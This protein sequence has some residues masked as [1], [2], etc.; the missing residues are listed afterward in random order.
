M[1]TF[2]TSK[3]DD[4]KG[5]TKTPLIPPA[6]P[7]IPVDKREDFI[8]IIM[9]GFTLAA[10]AGFVNAVAMLSSFAITVSHLT[11][12][13]TRLGFSLCHFDFSTAIYQFSIVLFYCFGCVLVGSFISNQRFYYSRK[14]GIFLIFE[15]AIIAIAA[16]LFLQENKLGIYFAAFGMGV[17]NS[18]FS[19][20]SGAVVRTT[21]VTG[22]VTDIGLLFG[23]WIRFKE[24]PKELWRLKVFVPLYVGYVFGA[25]LAGWFFS[26]LGVKAMYIPCIFLCATGVIWTLWRMK[27][28]LTKAEKHAI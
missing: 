25:L 6:A 4:I 16:T 26:F 19:N 14:Y 11:G 3:F 15:S 23:H 12:V 21:H 22:L 27:Y 9:G 5:Q 8:Y 1:N 2:Q 24:P 7:D 28:K 17:Q 18:L 10:C 20:F 13:S